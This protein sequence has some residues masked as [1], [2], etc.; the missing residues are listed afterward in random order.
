MLT[1]RVCREKSEKKNQ[2][3]SKFNRSVVLIGVVITF[4]HTLTRIAKKK[5]K[6][7][8]QYIVCNVFKNIDNYKNILKLQNIFELHFL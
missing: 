5:L 4:Q 7:Q 8:K 1:V 6:I 3:K 2:V